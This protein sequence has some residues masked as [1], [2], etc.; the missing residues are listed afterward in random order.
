MSKHSKVPADPTPILEFGS[1]CAPSPTNFK[2]VCDV[3]GEPAFWPNHLHRAGR[4]AND[5]RGAT[6][7]DVVVVGNDI[8]MCTSGGQSGR[9][10]SVFTIEDEQLRVRLVQALRYGL[11]LYVAAYEQI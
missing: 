4:G 7:A 1:L 6:I 5:F 10:F 8:A 3:I 11:S 2:R 9:T